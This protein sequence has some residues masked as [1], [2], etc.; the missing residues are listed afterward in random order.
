MHLVVER[1]LYS[2]SV[3]LPQRALQSHQNVIKP[4][5]QYSWA[6]LMVAA[7]V[8]GVKND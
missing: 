7:I 3:P 5:N 1:Q 4:S 2:P 8:V 6:V